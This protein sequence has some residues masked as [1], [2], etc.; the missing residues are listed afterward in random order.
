MR[1]S[2]GTT[3]VSDS[4]LNVLSRVPRHVRSAIWISSEDHVARRL[5]RAPPATHSVPTTCPDALFR[6]YVAFGEPRPVCDGNHKEEDDGGARVVQE[7][8]TG[9]SRG[10]G[11]ASDD[12]RDLVAS[13][14]DAL[15]HADAGEQ[16]TADDEEHD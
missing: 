8:L 14:L 16:Q 3:L 6:H 2:L 4:K 10:V 11:G 12:R 13:G 1:R 5:S 7:G 9:F 15:P